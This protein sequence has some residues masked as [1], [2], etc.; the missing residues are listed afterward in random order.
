MK[1][2]VKGRKNKKAELK[3]LDASE[4]QSTAPVDDLVVVAE[5]CDMI[6][7]G[8]VSTGRVSRGGDKP[9]HTAINGENYHA[10]KALTW[11]HRGKVDAIYI[12]PPYTPEI[13]TGNTTTTT[14]M[15][16]TCI[17]TASGWP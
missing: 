14:S 17:A 8:L 4:E 16:T 12:D 3:L 10:L 11:T 15:P 6:F 9:W 2:I 7:P 13:R 5:F 1:K